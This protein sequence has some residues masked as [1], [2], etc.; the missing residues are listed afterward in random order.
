M[1]ISVSKT[2]FHAE[3]GELPSIYIMMHFSG[4]DKD[5]DLK[6]SAINSWFMNS[7][8]E[9]KYDKKNDKLIFSH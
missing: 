6:A 3:V 5:L 1:Q 8:M 7:V 9:V 2:T 4:S